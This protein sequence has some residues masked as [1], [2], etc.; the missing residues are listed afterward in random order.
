MNVIQGTKWLQL[1]ISLGQGA[2]GE[3]YAHPTCR[4]LAIKIYKDPAADCEPE[5]IDALCANPP[6]SLCEK[7]QPKFAWPLEPVLDAASGEMCGFVMPRVNKTVPLSA[8]VHPSARLLNFTR[9]WLWWTAIYFAKRIQEMH[10][11]SPP[12][13]V[14]DINFE[15]S[16]VGR[17]AIVTQLD[18]DSTHFTAPSG[19]TFTTR[20]NRWEFQP[21]ELLNARLP[22]LDLDQDQDAWRTYAMVYRLLKE[23]EHPFDFVYRGPGN[24]PDLQSVI[25]DGH[26]AQSLRDPQFRPKPSPVPFKSFPQ[27]LQDL[28]R[29]MFFDGHTNRGARPNVSDLLSCLVQHKPVGTYFFNS[30]SRCAWE[31]QLKALPT[32]G[33]LVSRLGSTIKRHKRRTTVAGFAA[34]LCIYAASPNHDELQPP[35]INSQLTHA[36]RRP[37]SLKNFPPIPATDPAAPAGNLRTSRPTPQLWKQAL[38]D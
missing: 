13:I 33:N 20:M 21:P 15:N 17:Q 5:R 9:P 35:A 34:A 38:A 26:W 14:G 10:L 2:A 8:I 22:I 18:I 4:Q 23:G 27:D 19:I 36:M 29:Q 16:H 32:Q 31:R 1:T 11:H 7:G 24:R 30:P 6:N 3:V 28:F 25:Q 12:H 37:T